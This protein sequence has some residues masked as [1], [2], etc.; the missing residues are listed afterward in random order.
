MMSLELPEA[1]PR[2]S[3]IQCGVHRHHLLVGEASFVPILLTVLV[4]V[5]A[6]K[7]IGLDFGLFD[8]NSHGVM[9]IV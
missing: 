5:R 7:S 6:Y 2:A 3:K 1:H 4:R 8:R 9:Y